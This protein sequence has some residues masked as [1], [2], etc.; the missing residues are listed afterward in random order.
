MALRT[1]FEKRRRHADKYVYGAKPDPA[2]YQRKNLLSLPLDPNHSHFLFVDK[3]EDPEGNAALGVEQEFRTNLEDFIA[4]GSARSLVR[5]RMASRSRRRP[6]C[7]SS[8]AAGS[9]RC[10]RRTSS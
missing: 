7:S 4:T 1:G 6:W 5:T 8:S 9:S 2:S 3:A 10:C